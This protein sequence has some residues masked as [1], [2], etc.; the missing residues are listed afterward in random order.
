ML[1]TSLA[2]T[3]PA[4]AR[5]ACVALS[6]AVL[7]GCSGVSRAPAA[8]S[9]GAPAPPP[10]AQCNAQAAQFAVGQNNTASVMES[11]RARSGA[12]MAR[13][14]RPG[15]VTTREFNAQRL[16]LEVDASGRIIAARC[17]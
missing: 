10:V 11:A 1:K 4:A 3:I 13:V 12:Q 14:L 2:L 5:F 17:G 15:Q 8:S 16:N 6:L 9:P 7:G